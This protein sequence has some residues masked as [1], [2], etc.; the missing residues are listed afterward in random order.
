MPRVPKIS[1]YDLTLRKRAALTR[2][3]I[4]RGTSNIRNACDTVKTSSLRSQGN[5]IC[6]RYVADN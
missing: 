5:L 6:K 2:I 4:V 1:A 3:S